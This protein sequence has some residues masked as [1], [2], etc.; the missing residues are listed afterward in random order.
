MSGWKPTISLIHPSIQIK[1]VRLS[2]TVFAAPH[3]SLLYINIL[4]Y[5]P[6][7]YAF[8]RW[9]NANPSSSRKTSLNMLWLVAPY[10]SI[11]IPWAEG[12]S[13]YRG[14]FAYCIILFFLY[15]TEFGLSCLAVSSI[16]LTPVCN[17]N[18]IEI[19]VGCSREQPPRGA[20][21]VSGLVGHFVQT[22][23]DSECSHTVH[24]LDSAV[25]RL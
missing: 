14:F 24:F 3:C 21:W 4:R 23:P 19:S 20:P 10:L 25:L 18:Y 5:I 16:K 9:I 12:Q 15:F 11:K 13:L 7:E 1:D 22:W 17:M 8:V 2:V 6:C